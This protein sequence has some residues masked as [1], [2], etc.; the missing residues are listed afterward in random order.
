MTSLPRAVGGLSRQELPRPRRNTGGTSEFQASLNQGDAFI[1]TKSL[2][3]SVTRHDCKWDYLR[4]SGK[5]GQNR[6]KLSTAVRCTHEPSGAV[7]YAEDSRSQLDN[8]RMAFKRMAESAPFQKWQRIE[9]ARR[10]GKIVEV[11]ESVRR[12]MIPSKIRIEGKDE[13]GRWSVDAIEP[14]IDDR[15]AGDAA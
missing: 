12:Q 8:R 4:G 14:E 13:R 1:L 11:E 5:G 10:M 7:G 9:S 6:N 3:F 15:S 2:L